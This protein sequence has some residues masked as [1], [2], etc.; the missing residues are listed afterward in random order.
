MIAR[1]QLTLDVE[2][3]PRNR[4]GGMSTIDEAG[5]ETR[6]IRLIQAVDQG[7]RSLPSPDGETYR[8]SAAT[9]ISIGWMYMDLK[10]ATQE[11]AAIL[12]RQRDDGAIPERDGR[13]GVA[14]PLVASIH[15][16]IYHAVRVR[17]RVLEPQLAG[18]VPALDRFHR[19]L[20]G[21][22]K[23]RLWTA[24]PEDVRIGAPRSEPVQEAGLNALLVQADT[25][26]ANV[27]IHVGR[28]TR[29]AVGRRTHRA[30]ALASQL[31]RRELRAFASRTADGQWCGLSGAD[32]LP[33][34]AGAALRTQAAALIGTHL[35]AFWTEHGL[36]TLPGDSDGPREV[37]PLLSW[38]MV[39]G[40]Y[41]Y[42]D[43]ERARRLSEATLRLAARGLHRAYDA[44]TGEPTDRLPWA[45][46]AA[47]VLDLL[48]TPFHYDRW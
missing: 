37:D 33:L 36:A 6:C 47:L 34:W 26:L 2:W 17:R 24:D 1:D 15:R 13:P 32:L 41:R 20:A 25:D 35:G 46:T 23:R 12:A 39:R 29:D 16:M 19:F 10:R 30:Q 42:G 27:S 28:P 14:L 4:V 22:D 5:L 44:A 7:E 3:A 43:D 45:P 21:R 9:V 8:A 18:Q 11:L 38:L 31:W 48:K 40:L